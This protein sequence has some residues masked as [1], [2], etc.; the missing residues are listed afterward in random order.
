M[1]RGSHETLQESVR[2][3]DLQYQQSTYDDEHNKTRLDEAKSRIASNKTHTIPRLKI[4]GASILARLSNTITRHFFCQRCNPSNNRKWLT[5][6]FKKIDN[7]LWKNDGDIVHEAKISAKIRK[8]TTQRAAKKNTWNKSPSSTYQVFVREH[9][10]EQN[11]EDVIDGSNFTSSK[12]LFRVAGRV[13]WLT[14]RFRSREDNI[15]TI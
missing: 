3:G 14:W 12:K 10:R 8:Q 6:A 5:N 1:C 11:H 15:A 4:F 2:C 7:W 9:R 13:L